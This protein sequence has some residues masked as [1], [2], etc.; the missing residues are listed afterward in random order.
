[1][2]RGKGGYEGVRTEDTGKVWERLCLG[3]M[4]KEV[5]IGTRYMREVQ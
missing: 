5:I 1:M 4:G 2:D 3:Q